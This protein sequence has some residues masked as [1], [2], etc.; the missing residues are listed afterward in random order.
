MWGFRGLF[1][2]GS[3]SLLFGEP[4]RVPLRVGSVRIEIKGFGVFRGFRSLGV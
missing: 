3:G 4:R 2:L 1:S